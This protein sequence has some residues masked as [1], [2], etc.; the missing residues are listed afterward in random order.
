[1]IGI[2]ILSRRKL[3]QEDPGLVRDPLFSWMLTTKEQPPSNELF[4]SVLKK[5]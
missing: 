5:N 2:S 4:I 3:T 1:M